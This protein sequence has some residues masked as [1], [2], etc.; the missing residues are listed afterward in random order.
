MSSEV[1][2]SLSCVSGWGV[3][4]E[5]CYGQGAEQLPAL[6]TGGGRSAQKESRNYKEPQDLKI[7]IHPWLRW[8]YSHHQPPVPRPAPQS[9]SPPANLQVLLFT[10]W[11]NKPRP[12]TPINHVHPLSLPAYFS[13]SIRELSDW[14][15]FLFF[16]SNTHLW[17]IC[18]S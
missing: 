14:I 4:Y 8:L 12:N 5:G 16:H 1:S 10:C 13:L 17:D 18:N 6:A 11:S 2:L 15:F 9:V 7:Y 3:V